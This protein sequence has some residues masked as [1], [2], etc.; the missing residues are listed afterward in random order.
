MVNSQDFDV[1]LVDAVDLNIGHGEKQQ[2]PRSFFTSC[3]AAQRPILQRLN[4]LV[5]LA[6]GRLLVLR[7][8]FFQV[9]VDVFEV[10]GGG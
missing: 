4:R 2:L 10:C 1:L 9:A 3:M 5:E 6:Y 8:A 7:M